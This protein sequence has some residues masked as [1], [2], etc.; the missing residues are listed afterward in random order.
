MQLIF[1]ANKKKRQRKRYK[2]GSE[3][4]G[5]PRKKVAFA[6]KMG[7]SPQRSID[8]DSHAY[9]SNVSK[10]SSDDEQADPTWEIIDK[11]VQQKEATVVNTSQGSSSAEDLKANDPKVSN[12]DPVQSSDEKA[13]TATVSSESEKIVEQIQFPKVAYG[14]H[15]NYNRYYGFESLNKNMDVRLKI[16]Q[17]NVHLFK[18]KDV[19]D[20]GCNCGLMTLAIAR[21]F[22]PKSITGID[23]D[24]KLINIARTKLKKYVAVPD[25][26]LAS[27]LSSDGVMKYRNRTECFP[28]SFPICYGNLSFAFK[29]IQKKI[30]TP[31]TLSSTPQTPQNETQ[32]PRIPENVSFEEVRAL[33]IR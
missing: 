8:P 13:N 26:L 17:R 30:Q 7:S 19:L 29:Q 23:I 14:Q 28:I 25:R 24:K 22:T 27:D 5:G 33:I 12:T 4:Y 11:G 1:N 16:F 6:S 10:E 20:V 2:S 9:D 32:N 21:Y 31:A 18:N 3:Y 15:G